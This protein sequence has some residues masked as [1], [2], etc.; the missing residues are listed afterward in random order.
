MSKPRDPAKERFWRHILEQFHASGLSVAAFCRLH[1]LPAGSLYA[2]RRT[3]ADRDR[4]AAAAEPPQF[5]PVLLSATAMP[6][7]APAA[8]ELLLPQG[9]VLRVPAGFDADSL[10]RL[11]AVLEQPGE[12][13][14]C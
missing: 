4:R 3:L 10:R 14:P 9:R 8:L 11:L 2:W 12:A 5:V 13:P 6:G 7:D 1:H